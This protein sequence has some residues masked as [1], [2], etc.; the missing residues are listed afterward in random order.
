MGP[1]TVDLPPPSPGLSEGL[2]SVF[3][4]LQQEPDTL[5]SIRSRPSVCVVPR[6]MWIAFIVCRDD[7][8]RFRRAC[9]SISGGCPGDGA[10]VF[11]SLVCDRP[12]VLSLGLGIGLCTPLCCRETSAASLGPFYCL[13]QTGIIC[14][15]GPNVSSVQMLGN[16]LDS[17]MDVARMNFSHGSYDWFRLVV[18]NWR[19]AVAARPGCACAL[20]LD[21]KGPEIR[22]GKNVAGDVTYEAGSEVTVTVNDSFKNEGNAERIY[23]DY[24]DLPTTVAPGGLIYIDDGLFCLEVVECHADCVKCIA[25]NRSCS[26]AAWAH[27]QKLSICP[28]KANLGVRC[29]GGWV[30]GG[31]G[32]CATDRAFWSRRWLKGIVFWGSLREIMVK[33]RC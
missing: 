14:T 33:Y 5:F 30:S 18:S 10:H 17:G 11:A 27:T 3:V 19:R 28:S 15:L 13:R 23:L 8:T 31:W 6:A 29:A 16:L 4:E 24:K 20:A 25:M 9:E 7:T 32:F 21:T 2:S 26:S 1:A 12:G 22:T